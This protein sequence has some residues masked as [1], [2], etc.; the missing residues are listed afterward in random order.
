MPV[1]LAGLRARAAQF[2]TDRAVVARYTSVSTSDGIE[3]TWSTVASD[4]PCQVWPSGVSGNEAVG[5]GAELRALSTWTV[6]L[7]ALQDVTV[8]DRLTIS[9]GRVFEVQRVDART[10]EAARDCICELVQ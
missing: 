5:A 1:P 10:Y 3:Q 7:P 9:D 2:M 6:R 4:V 8:R